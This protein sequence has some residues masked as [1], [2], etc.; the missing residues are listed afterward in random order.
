MAQHGFNTCHVF[1]DNADTKEHYDLYKQVWNA[2]RMSDGLNSH[3]AVPKL[4]LVRH[5]YIAPTDEQALA[6]AKPA[7]GTWFHNINYLWEKNGYDF[8]NF[9]RDFDDLEPRDIVLAGS[10]DTVREKVQRAIDE[11]GRQL[12]LPNLCLGR[13]DSQTRSC[14]RWASLLTR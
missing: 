3:V 11:T 12:L 14:D 1:A 10:P 8:L 13:P 7:F 5:M 9:I 4:G 6:E 2:E